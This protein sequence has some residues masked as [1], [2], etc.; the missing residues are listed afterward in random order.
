MTRTLNL[1]RLLL[2]RRNCAAEATQG[3]ASFTLLTGVLLMVSC[4]PAVSVR[5]LYTDEDQGPASTQ[6]SIEG[7]WISPSLNEDGDKQA[8]LTWKVTTSGVPGIYDVEVRRGGE[9]PDEPVITT[10]YDV[11]LVSLN[12]KLFFDA[13]FSQVSKGADVSTREGLELGTIPVHVPGRLTIASDMLVVQFLGS[14]WINENTPESFQ[15]YV[16]LGGKTDVAVITASTQELRDFFAKQADNLEALS[17]VRYLCRPA[18]DCIAKGYEYALRRNPKDADSLDGLIGHSLR[19]GHYGR[20]AELL[21]VD[22]E[23]KPTDPSVRNALG[24]AL[25]M[26]RKYEAARSAFTV[27][28]ELEPENLEALQGIGW[29][30]FLDGDFARAAATFRRALVSS[31][32][33]S[34]EPALLA[35]AALR[36]SG[37]AVEADALLA[38]E[39]AEFEGSPEDH[40]LLLLY[41]GRTNSFPD[42]ISTRPADKARH[43]LLAAEGS[44]SK[45]ALPMQDLWSCILAG[46]KDNL[47]S[48]IARLELEKLSSLPVDEK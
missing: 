45:G 43:H 29:S 32:N 41:A 19:S 5:P 40:L 46:G 21:K 26:D 27:A 38:K 33:I 8:E 20:A 22:S 2:R 18:T 15:K 14:S 30:Y 42:E 35:Y 10:R 34:A 23:M 31:G 12:G 25:L 11:Q 9:K 37:K 47:Y 7:D 28:L 13:D 39:I 24:T 1:S 17:Y 48:V 44:L 4:T 6:P 3:L 36:R 16:S